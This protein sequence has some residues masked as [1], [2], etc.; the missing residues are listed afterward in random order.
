MWMCINSTSRFFNAHQQRVRDGEHA[1]HAPASRAKQG[2]NSTPPVITPVVTGT[3]GPDGWYVSDIVVEWSVSDP[4]SEIVNIGYGCSTATF[5]SDFIYAN[6]TCEATSHGGTTT[7]SVP[8]KRDTTAP[9]I[10]VTAPLATIYSNGAWLMP[11]FNCDDPY[12]YSGVASCT[13]IEGSSPLDTTPGRHTFTVAATDVAGNTTTKSVEYLV[14][15]GACVTPPPAPGNLKGW[16]KFDGNFHDSIRNRDAMWNAGPGTFQTSVANQGWNSGSGGFTVNTSAASSTTAVTSSANPSTTGQNVTLTATVTGPG[17][18]TGSVSF[19]DGATLLG[20]VA[21]SDATAQL[22]TGSLATGGHAITARY[23][24]NATIPP[25]TSPAFAQYV[26][27]AGATTRTSTTALAASPSPATLGSTVA[28][29]ATVTGSQNK[30]PSGV[31]LFVLNGSVLGQGTL[32]QTGKPPRRYRWQR[33]RRRTARTKWRRC[34]S[35]TRRSARAGC[36][37]PWWSTDVPP[38]N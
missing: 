20:T 35:A 2:L 28:L 31:V 30:A 26:Q 33:A 1:P 16:W 32:S 12:G 9:G 22:T 21:L 18:L 4:D 14:G 11:S 29:T 7:V 19:Y 8:L 6:P 27:P 36:P 3:I 25:S 34:T 15:T 13:V 38:G 37:S 17:G 24:G 10:S 23:L 5:T